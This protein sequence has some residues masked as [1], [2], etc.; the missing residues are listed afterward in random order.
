MPM[1][2]QE[3]AAFDAAQAAAEQA[4]TALAEA[5]NAL[6]LSQAEVRSLKP[7]ERMTAV[8]EKIE[9]LKKMGF[10]VYPGFL[11]KCQEFMLADDSEV[12]VVLLS[13]DKKTERA[14]N[15]TEIIEELV[16]ALPS[17]NG[18]LKLA[19][20]HSLVEG[21]TRPATEEA[22]PSAEDR[23]RASAIDMYGEKEARKKGLIPATA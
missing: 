12:S 2:E 16:G 15:V 1:T 21:D 4:A 20:Q 14:L 5:Q 11:A 3:Q 13:A 9:G 6:Q 7:L 8:S 19:Q 10:D 17:E 18:K 23:L 22:K